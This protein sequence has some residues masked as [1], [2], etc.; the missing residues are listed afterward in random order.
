MKHH[1]RL[2]VLFFSLT[3]RLEETASINKI[4]VEVVYDFILS[5]KF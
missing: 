4:R 2:L 5:I 3:L 1:G